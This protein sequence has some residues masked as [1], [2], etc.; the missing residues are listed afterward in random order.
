MLFDTLALI[1]LIVAIT[2]LR[3]IVNIFPSL[4]ACMIRWKENINLQIR[5]KMR[6]DRNLLAAVLSIPFCLTAFRFRLYSPS[7]MES[8]TDNAVLGITFAVFAGYLA[9]RA[10]CRYIFRLHKSPSAIYETAADS[11]RTYFIVLTFLLMATGGILSFI[12]VTPEH[13]K[14]AMFWLSGAMYLVFLIRKTQIF[15]SSC[16]FFVSFLYLCAL[17]ILPTGVLITSAVIF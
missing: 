6:T 17:E 11:S 12:G 9:L 5:L 16:S 4:M 8:M 13:I 1:S 7:F 15:N 2:L 14:T 10:A 3:R